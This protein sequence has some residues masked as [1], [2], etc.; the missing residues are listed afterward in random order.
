MKHNK[1]KILKSPSVKKQIT[2]CN[3]K[4]EKK[5]LVAFLKTLTDKKYLKK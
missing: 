5:D 1:K 4:K 2:K 3:T